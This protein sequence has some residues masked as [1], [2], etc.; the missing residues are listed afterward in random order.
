[1]RKLAMFFLVLTFAYTQADAQNRTITG[2]VVD[3]DG[4]PIP[5][6]S[7]TARG[8]KTGSLTD[9]SGN[10][11]FSVGADVKVLV[12][13]SVGQLTQELRISS[14]N[15]Y[16]IRMAPADKSLD[17]VVVVGYQAIKRKDLNGA[18]SVISAKEIAQRPMQNFTQILQGKAPGLQ[19]VGASGQP[20]AAG[21]LRIRGTGSINAS[22]EPL[23]MIDGIAVTST[24]FSLLN[25]NDIET[26]SVLKDASSAAIY[27]S[28]AS[29]GV[30]VVTTKNGKPGAP[31]VRYSYQR[32]FVSLQ[33]LKNVSFMSAA[34][35]LKWEYEVGLTNPIIDSMIVN[36][37]G[38]AFPTNATLANI[39]DAQRQ[40][41]WDLMVSRAPSNWLDYYLQPGKTSSHEV[42]ISGATEKMKYY[43]SVNTFDEDGIVYKSFRNRIGARLNAEYKATSW[44]TTGINV[45]TAY[46]KEYQTRELFNSQAPWT[47][48]FL[49]NPYEPVFLPNGSY[50]LTMQGFSALE[51]QDRNT[52]FNNNLSTFA[53]GF[54][55]GKVNKNITL[56]S[57]AALNYNTN[58][59]E[60]YLQPG[61]NLA[62]ILGFNQ[63]SD[64]GNND[65]Q[66][67]ITNT[68]NWIQSFGS[69]HNVNV[70][71][72]QEFT[73]RNF[74]SYT[75]AA[76]GFPTASVN[77]LDNAATA[78]TATTSRS[79][80]SIISYFS[81][82]GYDFDKKYGVK[83]SVRRDGSSRFGANNRFANFWAASA[84]WN[85]K[86]EKFMDNVNFLSDLKVRAS[87]GTAGN[88]PNQF[89]GSLG[90]YALNVAYNNLPAAVPTQIANPDLTWEKNTNWDIGIDFG[91]FEN[92]ITG[93][94]DYYN[95]KTNDLL[96]PQPV[97][98]ATGFSSILSNIGSLTN[99]GI[100]VSLTGEIIRKK[101]LKWSVTVAYSNNKNNVN[102]LI[103]DNVPSSNNTRLVI[104]Q[105]LNTYYMVRWAGVNPANGR[106][107]YFAVDGS[108][109]ETYSLNNAVLLRDKSPLAKYFGNINSN[110]TYK[111]FDFSLQ[112]Y[113][114]GGNYI[115]NAMY[116]NN[117]A[118]GGNASV[119]FRPQYTDAGKYWRRPG[120]NAS[121]P[122]ITEAGQKQNLT[123]DRFL[124]KGDYISLRD[125]MIGYTL[126]SD[127]ARSLKLAGLRFYVQ[128]TN[129]FIGTKFRGIP[130][131]GLANRESGTPVQPGVLSLYAY[132]NT[133]TITVGVDVKF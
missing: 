91:L 99:K 70:L 3:A 54:L 22:N 107:Q 17:E 113:Y 31:Q 124:E 132:P 105:P 40:G 103:S 52:F 4:K 121:L 61:S 114:S 47:A 110:L 123:T 26:I 68:A 2:K 45:S 87:Y 15:E 7:I 78:Q 75:L 94:L 35:K 90:T 33:E 111:N 30:I 84:W 49:T 5:G 131:V 66:Y 1:M 37:R 128:G 101:D 108:V 60:S 63:K 133:R 129:L 67:V 24:A 53:T 62:A 57:V 120:D 118:D 32:G 73:K 29:N 56:K 23:I 74:Y 59:S 79:Q 64:G 76:R 109:T 44:L 9:E 51:G 55:E 48:Y 34:E 83:L 14:Q 127:L 119:G 25:P 72:G 13:S 77:T 50:N 95:R 20:G 65:F 88:V 80:W 96:Y 28:R 122:N 81:S 106:N 42:S 46:A 86:N 85:A 126:P 116:Q 100:E 104:G 16:S 38:S 12:I 18:T 71:L 8:T 82:V 125:L 102:S 27:G 69:K 10:F 36:R 11:R 98:Q 97:S 6:A 41:L 115:Y 112:F 89:Y 19:V 117:L 21:F 39:T 130:E 92:R 43:F 93:T 58:I